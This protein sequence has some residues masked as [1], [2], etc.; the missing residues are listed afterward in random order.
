MIQGEPW[1]GARPG[2]T[3]ELTGQCH[4]SQKLAMRAP[5]ARRGRGEPHRR[6][7]GQRGGLTRSGDDETKRRRTELSATANGAQR[8]GEKESAR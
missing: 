5:T 4:A 6:N 2:L 8:R 1:V 7:K 3:R